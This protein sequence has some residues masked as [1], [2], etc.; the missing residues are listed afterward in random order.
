[1]KGALVNR[2]KNRRNHFISLPMQLHTGFSLLLGLLF[3]AGKCLSLWMWVVLL[4]FLGM[5]GE[6]DL[7]AS[8]SKSERARMDG[9]Q[10]FCLLEL[11]WLS[12]QF[13]NL[14]LNMA[15]D[16]PS[17]IFRSPYY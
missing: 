11:N 14:F 5:K 3:F 6:L 17:K 7:R 2:F 16:P 13:S 8:F 4:F 12:N 15:V 9:K 1:M 10:G